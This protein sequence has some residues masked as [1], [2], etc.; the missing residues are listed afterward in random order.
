M[1]IIK[2]ISIV[3]FLLILTFV[4]SFSSFAI[5]LKE[6]EEIA[7][8]FMIKIRSHYSIISDPEIADYVSDL[9]EKNETKI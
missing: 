1:T 8:E 6:E 7:H 2:R 5:T 9:G 3:S 4:F